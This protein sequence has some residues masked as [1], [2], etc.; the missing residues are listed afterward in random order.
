MSEQTEGGPYPRPEPIC[1][2]DMETDTTYLLCPD[3]SCT[4]YWEKLD[5]WCPCESEC[6]LQDQLIKMIRCHCGEV[7]ELRGDHFMCC[8][9]GHPSPDGLG[10]RCCSFARMT[11]KYHLLYERPLKGDAQEDLNE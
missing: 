5:Q 2:E 3:Q 10:G 9:V 11:G 7:V 8:S 4:L 1:K 6:P